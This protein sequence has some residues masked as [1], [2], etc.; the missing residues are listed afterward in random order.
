MY[1]SHRT[2]SDV[3]IMFDE[4]VDGE[5]RGRSPL[6]KIRFGASP[7]S[8]T[9]AKQQKTRLLGLKILVKK[10]YPTLN[11]ARKFVCGSCAVYSQGCLINVQLKMKANLSEAAQSRF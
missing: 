3:G 10:S 4:I 1:Y 8:P 6:G 7:G 5:S 2:C 9:F 11:F